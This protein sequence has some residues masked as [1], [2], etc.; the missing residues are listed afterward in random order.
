MAGDRELRSR[1]KQVS[2]PKK[3]TSVP[4]IKP[5][6]SVRSSNNSGHSSTNSRQSTYTSNSPATATVSNG[7]SNSLLNRILCIESRIS[8]IESDTA[9]QERLASVE[10][11]FDQIKEENIN[12]RRTIE[13]LRADLEV[14][15]LLSKRVSDEN[16]ELKLNVASLT[17]QIVNFDKQQTPVVATSVDGISPEQQELNNNIV[18]RGIEFSETSEIRPVEVYESIR[19]H[20]GVRQDET[21]DPVSVK[22]FPSAPTKSTTT[23]TIQVKFKT[24]AAKRQ[25]LQVRRVKKDITPSD[26]GIV[27]GSKKALLITEQLTKNNQELLYAARSLRHTHKYK[28]VWSNN[29]QVLV[30]PQQYSKVI[31]I[32][33]IGQ[34]NELRIINNL[35]PL[36]LKNGRFPASIN[37]ESAE[38]N[39]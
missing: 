21:F 22:V 6:S 35:E 13:Q 19:T 31:R 30:R 28:Y 10:T 23:K 39:A 34:V 16:V 1:T 3:A 5:S 32:T 8:T 36:T 29:G 37:I 27:Q 18:I 12:L 9:F 33:D 15:Q 4:T 14:V 17:T 20:L 2:D 38:G 25:F 11:A 7:Q 24:V 26:L